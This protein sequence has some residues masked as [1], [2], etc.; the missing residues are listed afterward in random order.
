MT[1]RVKTVDVHSH[2]LPREMLEAIRRRPRD[3][4]MSVEAVSG[5]EIFI[6][7]D[8]HST[9]VFA[10]FH[11]ADA[12]VEGMDRRGIDISVISVSPVVFFYWL[13]PEAGL[14]AA[15]V[16]NDG[17]AR[18]VEA[19]PDR[20]RGMATLP[21]QDPDAAV[22]ELERVVKEHGFRAIEL[23]CRVRGELISEPRF[24]PV[25]RR[26]Q[27]LGAFIFTHPYI[28]GSLPP[29]LSCYYLGN[30]A[31]LPF[32]TALMAAHLMFGGALDA[33]PGLNVVLAHGGGHLP[34]QIGRLAHGHQ[35]RKEGKAHTAN[36]PLELLRRFY[37]D[38]LTHDADALRFLV[39]KAGADRVTIGT[40]APY[41]MGED[42]PV[43]MINTLP[44]SERDRDRILGLN[45][46][47]L[48]GEA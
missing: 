23:G 9:P 19:R 16:L 33:L 42:D 29:D 17:I 30:L 46:L 38:A 25:L 22:T 24:R 41:D 21:M 14:A 43:G 10:E 18:M 45:A 20:L 5:Q 7:D 44:V 35:V 48:L 27:E 12:K 47:E 15:R 1:R 28:E 40:D 34:Y 4:Q 3:Y 37:F 36:S 32:D 31:G 6:R 39:A 13:A 26:A 2:V 11:D 8:R